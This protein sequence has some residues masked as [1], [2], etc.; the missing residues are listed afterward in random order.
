[1]KDCKYVPRFFKLTKMG[2][3]LLLWITLMDFS[4]AEDIA[5][6]NFRQDGFPN[7]K[8]SVKAAGF[9]LDDNFRLENYS[10]CVR[11]RVFFHNIQNEENDVFRYRTLTKQP[12]DTL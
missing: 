11:Y 1:M 4:S 2:V 5:I 7:D 8:I 10:L 3:Y 12:K 9:G 6:F